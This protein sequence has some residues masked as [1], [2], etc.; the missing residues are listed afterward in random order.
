MMAWFHTSLQDMKE[1]IE[2]EDW[3]EVKKILH[4]HHPS[5]DQ[6]VPK[7]EPTIHNLGYRISQYGEDI[8]QI[9]RMLTA[10][11]KGSYAKDLMLL[12][13][14]SAL[15]QVHL[16]EET[17][18]HLIKEGKFMMEQ[19]IVS[20]GVV[21]Y[22][23]KSVLL[24]R[25]TQHA[26]VVT[27]AYGF[28]AGRVEDGETLEQAAIRELE[29]ETGLKTTAEYLERLPEKRST[30]N[31]KNGLENFIFQPFLCTHYFGELRPSEKTIPE[32]IDLERIN[33]LVL[34]TDD[35]GEIA[36]TWYKTS[37]LK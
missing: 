22:Q 14:E 10:Q 15:N 35:I 4:H 16:F 34:I 26:K 17:I 24:V 32:F 23:E 11:M 19:R 18:Q 29:E 7:A 9:S 5:L 36:R 33:D 6:E 3:E 12:K 31:M 28:P 30:L 8:V 25:H 1:A 20:V 13:V 37:G 21:L 2:R 27:G